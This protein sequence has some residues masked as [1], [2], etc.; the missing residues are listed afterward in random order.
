MCSLNRP[1]QIAYVELDLLEIMNFTNCCIW[2]F[3]NKYALKHTFNSVLWACEATFTCNQQYTCRYTC[4]LKQSVHQIL[5]PAMWH[6]FHFMFYVLHLT[7]LTLKLPKTFLINCSW[8]PAFLPKITKFASPT[9]M[10][11]SQLPEG[12]WCPIS[13][14]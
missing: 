2:L 9:L 7:I 10:L 11:I 5:K 13:P 4:T 1:W 6:H 8:K 3:F 14:F 12:I